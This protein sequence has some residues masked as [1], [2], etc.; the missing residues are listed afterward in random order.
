M[1]KSAVFLLSLIITVFIVASW[2]SVPFGVLP[3]LGFQYS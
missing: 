2:L 3:P 1:Y